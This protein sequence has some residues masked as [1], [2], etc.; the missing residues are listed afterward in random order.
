MRMMKRIFTLVIMTT[1]V[2][3]SS[4]GMPASA[5]AKGAPDSFADLAERLLPM[6]VNVNTTQ[7]I[8]VEQR[9]L[10]PGM[11][12]FLKRYGREPRTEENGEQR[13]LTRK[14][15]SLGSGFIIDPSGIIITNNHVIDKADEIMIR[16]HDGRE[17]KATLVGTD[18]K[19]DIAVLKVEAGEPLPYA[20]FG[21]DSTARIGDW[22][23]AI[24]N[25][26]ALGG[27]VTA[28]II[29]ARNRDI[30]SGDYDNYIQTDASINM[31]NSGGPMFN[32]KGEVI[33]I[34]TAIFSQTGGNIG[35]G[36][37]IPANQAKHVIAQL[38][39]YGKTKR[40]RIGISF[41]AIDDDTAE[42][43]GMEKAQGSIVAS[44]V[45][46]GPADDAGILA[47]DII[48][49]FEGK[50]VK[51]RN[52]LPRWVSTTEIGK[53]VKIVVLRKGNRKKL[54]VV[55]DEL[56]EEVAE[57]DQD[58][59]KDDDKGDGN[60]PEVESQEILGMTLEPILDKDRKGLK[61]DDDVEG[62]LI[63]AV[64]RNS[65]AGEKGLRAGD[66]ILEITQEAV[67]TV[68]GAVSRIEELAESGRKSILLKITRQGN[69]AFVAVKFDPKK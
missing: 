50:I 48:I 45:P 67:T 39:K 53:K 3:G 12:E 30:N 27:T 56:V 57:D 47:G 4:L 23:I 11:E 35:I 43:L 66:V 32:M 55:I 33:G 46:G 31:G 2:V 24:G 28:G 42:A 22:I 36:F 13:P 9:A 7:T 68:S 60:D 20:K 69:T 6:V 19:L 38:R 1:M 64:D 49:E 63:A 25:P 37:A 18:D 41:N 21:D 59:N 62:V 58:A 51:T 40:G 52:D 8:K 14:R 54:T 29:S 17:L 15:Q 61:L 16:M 65:P 34:N 44:V 5:L 26:F 10:P